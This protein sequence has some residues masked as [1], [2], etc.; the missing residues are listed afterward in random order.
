MEQ[1]QAMEMEQINREHHMA[2]QA[3]RMELQRALDLTKTKVLP[4]KSSS[5]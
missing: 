2:L 1:K 5:Y 3:S 4:M